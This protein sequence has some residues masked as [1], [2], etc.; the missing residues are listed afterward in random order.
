MELTSFE[1]VNNII[2]QLYPYCLF[3]HV[4]LYYVYLRV[5]IEKNKK[6][7]MYF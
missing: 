1:S 4:K 3:T 2:F 7:I 5:W 6:Y